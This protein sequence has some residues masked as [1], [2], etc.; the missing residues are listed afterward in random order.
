MLP[1]DATQDDEDKIVAGAEMREQL[2]SLGKPEAVPVTT[3]PT[4]PEVGVR[5]RMLIGPAIAAKS[6][7]AESPRPASVS[8]LTV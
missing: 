5:V 8:V 3:A 7:V 2:V 6:A 4:A 1:P